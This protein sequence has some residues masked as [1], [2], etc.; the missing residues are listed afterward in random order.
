M[1]LALSDDTPSSKA[2][3]R[4]ILALSSLHRHGLQLKAVELKVSSLNAL[5][6][7]SKSKLS[8]KEVIQHVAAGMLLCSF[9]VGI[10]SSTIIK[11]P[12]VNR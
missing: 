11:Y 1:R 5:A 2:V 7:A 6:I 12:G 9:E 10:S 3:L 4:S 8:I